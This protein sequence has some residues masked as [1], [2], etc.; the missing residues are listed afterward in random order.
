LSSSLALAAS[1]LQAHPG[2][3]LVMAC[4]QPALQALHLRQLLEGAAQAR[5]GCAATV[6]DGHLGI[7]AV[8]TSELL[9]HA[10]ELAGDQ[11][12]GRHLSA[13]PG[14]AV[15]RLAAPELQ[16]DIDSPENEQAAI[17]RGLLDGAK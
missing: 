2:P 4:D 10:F 14:D 3:V 6:H 12:F 1:A 15:W 11:G 7:P 9:R 5:S 16:F 17:A 13:M 8:I